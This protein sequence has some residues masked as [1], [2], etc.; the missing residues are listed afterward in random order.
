MLLK[1]NAH[2]RQGDV[3]K[4]LMTL[5]QGVHCKSSVTKSVTF[6]LKAHGWCAIQEDP[7]PYTKAE[8]A[9]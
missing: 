8:G 5:T 4:C 9:A 3:F 7:D 1:L 2:A 6:F